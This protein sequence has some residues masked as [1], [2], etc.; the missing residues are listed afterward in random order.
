M[1]DTLKKGY[2]SFKKNQRFKRCVGCYGPTYSVSKKRPAVNYRKSNR[3]QTL[4]S[5]IVLYHTVFIRLA[6]TVLFNNS[7]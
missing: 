3:D 2:P 7:L 1:F 5:L 4:K 6:V